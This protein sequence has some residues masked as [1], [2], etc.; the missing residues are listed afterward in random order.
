MSEEKAIKFITLLCSQEHTL[1]DKVE[2]VERF[3]D[4]TLYTE[5]DSKGFRN[6]L[7]R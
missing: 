4:L 6:D 1:I 3:L 5:S 2:I 7:D